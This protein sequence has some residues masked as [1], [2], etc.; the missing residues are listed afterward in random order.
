MR[1]L[2]ADALARLRGLEGVRGAAFVD[3]QAGVPVAVSAPADLNPDALAALATGFLGRI[4]R[5]ASSAEFGAVAAMQ[6]E[7]AGGHL[8]VVSG[9]NLLIVLVAEAG[10]QLST[11]RLEARRM[12]EEI[13]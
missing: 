9:V 13:R 3:A 11:L 4:S 2:L 8:L 5:A 6:L 7:G 1:E 10:A 12:A